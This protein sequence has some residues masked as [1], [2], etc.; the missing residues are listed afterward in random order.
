MLFNLEEGGLDSGHGKRDWLNVVG[1]QSVAPGYQQYSIAF[2]RKISQLHSFAKYLNYILSQNI[3]FFELIVPGKLNIPNIE[4][5]LVLDK[6]KA[7]AWAGQMSYII[8]NTTIR[9]M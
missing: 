4:C 1:R 7:L 9:L 6:G 3:V 5:I 8:R 2:Y